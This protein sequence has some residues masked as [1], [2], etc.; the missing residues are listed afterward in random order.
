MVIKLLITR[1]VLCCVGI[2]SCFVFTF[3]SNA[4]ETAKLMGIIL[5]KNNGIH[6]R[7]TGII[8]HDYLKQSSEFNIIGLGLIRLY[9]IGIA[10]QQVSTCVF[11]P[12]CSRFCAATLTRYGFAKG[13]LLTSDRLQRC[14][15]YAYGEYPVNDLTGKMNDLVEAYD[16][17][18]GVQ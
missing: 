9:Q 10:S 14:N 15:S 8:R 13:L 12:S 16:F 17:T 5:A 4:G 18:S 11:T 1:A 7:D 3:T 6:F 2:C